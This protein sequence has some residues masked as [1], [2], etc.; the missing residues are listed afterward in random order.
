[1]GTHT[2][3]KVT[4]LVFLVLFAS[5]H[6]SLPLASAS[7]EEANALLKWKSSLQNKSQSVLS[8]W[9]LLPHNATNSKPRTGP[10][11]WFGISCNAHGSVARM[12]LSVSGI[13]GTLDEF[14]FMSLPNLTHVDFCINNLS[15]VIP[16]QISYLSKLVYLD[17]SIN[18]FFGTIPQ[19]IGLLQHLEILHLAE[20]HFNGS[21]P[22]EIGQL[23]SLKE[24][25]MYTN[26]LEGP[27]PASLGNLTN[28]AWLSLSSSSFSGSIPPEMGNLSG[29]VELYIDNN[30]LSGPIPSTFG[31]LRNLTLFYL[32]NNSLSGPIPSELGYMTSLTYLSLQ[33]NNLSG[34]IPA[35]LGN[36]RNLHELKLY[37][38]QLS[39]SI[40][41]EIGNLNSLVDLELSENQLSGSLPSIFHN[42]T[43]LNILHLR[44]NQLSGSIPPEIEN[45]KLSILEIDHNQFTGQLPQN[46]CKGGLLR[47]FTASENQL[48][49][50]IPK[51][52]K[53]CTS[54]ERIVLGGNHLTGNISSDFGVYPNLYIIDLSHN[55][56]YGELSSSWGR[57]PKL[58][59]LMISGNN[60]T[61]RIPPEIGNSGQL[62]KLN[63]SSN[64]IVGDIPTELKR[65]TSLLELALNGNQLSGGVPIELGELS[66]LE[67]LDLSANNLSKEIPKSIGLLSKLHYLNLSRNEF[68]ESIPVQMGKLIQ[69]SD[70]DLSHNLLTGKIPKVFEG[71]QSLV[72]LNLSYNQLQGPV[73]DTPAF[74][75]ASLQGNKGLCG[76][77][78]GLMPCEANVLRK[79]HKN[80][81][82]LFVIVFPLSGSMILSLTVLGIFFS[83]KRTKDSLEKQESGLND[84]KLLSISAIDFDGRFLY[85]E[86]INSTKDFGAMYCI[87]KGR[88]GSVYRAELSSGDTVAVKKFHPLSDDIELVN[89]KEFLN[90]IRALTQ[91]RHRNIVKLYGFCAAP[92][93]SFLIYKY[94]EKGSL[95]TILSNDEAAKELDWEKRINVVKGIAYALSYMHH[96]SSPP[97]IHRDISSNNVLL[98][99]EFEAHV[100]DFGTAKLLEIDSAYW[101]K[102][103]GTCGYIAPELA[104]TMKVTKKCDVYSFGVLALEVIKGVHPGDVIP[105]MLSSSSETNVLFEDVLGLDQR[106]PPPSP[107]VQDKLRLIMKVASSCLNVNPESRP[108]MYSVSQMLSA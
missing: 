50:P 105:L 78:T 97:I 32:F 42:L 21:F 25:D 69:L 75:N 72:N 33:M 14:P 24:L 88:S 5:L 61:G 53:N 87:G 44:A 63:L 89:Q 55:K 79:G 12:N 29:L 59:T 9:T 96:D 73:P 58:A 67:V 71:L 76:N 6:S 1:M 39:G 34:A 100:S 27:I 40:P 30:L 106:L 54:L 108:T 26:N 38:N 81:K 47:N 56:F 80:K 68:S 43:S 8:S 15:G 41:N 101:T 62:R 90:E 77:V 17:F 66:Y 83:S 65:W 2:F 91:I 74:R 13:S 7:R 45:L 22:Q 60:I 10:C 46:L 48:Q 28:L 103:A 37:A 92:K 86:I 99:S 85:E 23:K 49:G 70:L 11:T 107:G 64:G 102:L 82:I 51:D 19:E 95:A 3:N 52:L 57:C 4:S 35:S 31:N 98:D 20:N 84:G 94:I 36:L 93:H 104:Y 16:P 18:Q